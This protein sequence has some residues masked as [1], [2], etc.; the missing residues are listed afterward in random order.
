MTDAP[1]IV[2]TEAKESAV[3]QDKKP[4]VAGP[5]AATTPVA[6]PEVAKK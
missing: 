5:A 4:K 1:K 2:A 6:Q 3:A